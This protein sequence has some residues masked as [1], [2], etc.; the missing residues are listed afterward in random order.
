M[1][2]V[3]AWAYD[4]VD[5]ESIANNSTANVIMGYVDGEVSEWP[6]S[7]WERFPGHRIAKITVKGDYENAL[8]ADIESGDMVPSD[9]EAFVR[10]RN[11][12]SGK[13]DATLYCSLSLVAEVVESAEKAG[14]P[15][16]LFV[17]YYT[18]DERPSGGFSLH[19]GHGAI[20]AQQFANFETYDQSAVYSNEWLSMLPRQPA[21]GE[22]S[23]AVTEPS[24]EEPPASVQ[25][26]EAEI[27]GY[28]VYTNPL[29]GYGGRAV[30]SL[31]NGANWQ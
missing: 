7:G 17:A 3:V 9:A 2:D 21:S 25:N 18:D 11:A 15:Y 1:S 10:N 28:V 29:G 16:W 8:I 19:T 20:C 31:D 26:P 5:P 23:E 22:R 14:Q 6:A 27:D 13:H 4:S 12:H 30:K 24:S